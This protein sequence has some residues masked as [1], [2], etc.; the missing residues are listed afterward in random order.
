MCDKLD[1]LHYILLL[2]SVLDTGLQQYADPAYTLP[3]FN[4]YNPNFSNPFT[5]KYYYRV[6][7]GWCMSLGF[8]VIFL[9]TQLSQLQPFTVSV[10]TQL[11]C[12]IV[13]V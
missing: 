9:E 2:E 13:M 8:K 3:D 7:C 5:K 6:S 10:G 12:V 4:L 1:I 11:K